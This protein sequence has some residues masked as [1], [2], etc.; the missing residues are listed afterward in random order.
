MPVG[1]SRETWTRWR[2]SNA[3]AASAAGAA[4]AGI[5]LKRG[6]SCVTEGGT[7]CLL[8]GTWGIGNG[9]VLIELVEAL[10]K[11]EDVVAETVRIQ[12]AL[13]LV[14]KLW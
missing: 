10:G 11:F 5:C 7:G 14:E 9:A 1:Q 12:R 6:R 2:S 8:L 13:H 3:A 4:T